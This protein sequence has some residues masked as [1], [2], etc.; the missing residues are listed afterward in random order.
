MGDSGGCWDDVVC[1]CVWAVDS[2]LDWTG[3]DWT[4]AKQVQCS[5]VQCSAVD[6]DVCYR[7]AR[8]QLSHR[9]SLSMREWKATL[10]Q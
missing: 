2:G 9:R 5:A 1:L 10:E 3:L 6:V 7:T 4:G 8:G